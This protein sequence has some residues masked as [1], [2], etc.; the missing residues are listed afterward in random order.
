MYVILETRHNPHT[1]VPGWSD[2]YLPADLQA[3]YDSVESL[4][5]VGAVH[6]ETVVGQEEGKEVIDAVEESKWLTDLKWDLP[7]V[8]V[9]YAHLAKPDV[10]HILQQHRTALGRKFV[11]VRMILN[12][13]PTW[14]QVETNFLKNPSPAFN[15]GYTQLANYGLSFDAQINP[16]QM[17]DAAAF[18][19]KHPNVPVALNHFGC[20]KFAS[21]EKPEIDQEELKVWREGMA[22]LA[23]LSHVFVKLSMF[24]YSVDIN[25]SEHLKFIGEIL[26]E[27]ITLF[28]V[29]RCMVASNY[30]VDKFQGHPL[31]N[32]L[33][34]D[35]V[36][37]W[38]AG[39]SSEDQDKLLSGVATDFYRIPTLTQLPHARPLGP[40]KRPRQVDTHASENYFQDQVAIITG[41]STGMGGGMTEY[42]ASRGAQVFNLDLAPRNDIG[43]AASRISTRK[44]NVSDAKAVKAIV[45]GILEETGGVVDYLICHAGIHRFS[46]VHSTPEDAFDLVVNVNIKGVFFA[47]QAVLPTMMKRRQGS[48]VVTGSDQALI[49]K[50]GQAVY[51]LT[52]A[53]VA[54]LVKSSAAEYAEYNIRV[55]SVCPGTVETPMVYGALS[56]LCN[57]NKDLNFDDV[58]DSLQT[59]Q[60]IRRLGRPEEI[61]F[62]V[63]SVARSTFMTGAIVPVDGGYTAV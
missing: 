10:E 43:T 15:R 5:L 55:N 21:A 52:K 22:A 34:P 26:N 54:Q 56:R 3:D 58:M 14:P 4:D 19:G 7:H 31:A 49:G 23:K 45:D 24:Q 47:M 36:G 12:H 25:N 1:V 48:I 38:L 46:S 8:A 6:I 51:G 57:E 63:G 37:G 16:H 59:A 50:P 42:F 28:G 30:P 60:P 62:V 2:S 33:G 32:L 27:T 40:L 41:G 11:G 35:G 29:D 20:P 61:A 13:E 9:A 17:L 53:A 44:V 39:Y 18:F